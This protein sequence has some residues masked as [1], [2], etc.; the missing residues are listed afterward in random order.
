MVVYPNQRR[1]FLLMLGALGFVVAC[2]LIASGVIE[3]R[4]PFLTISY[5]GVFF[6]GLCLLYMAWRLVAPKP[7]VIV[8]EQGVYDDASL[9]NAGWIGWDEIQDLKISELGQQRF[10]TIILKDEWEVLAR[11]NLPKRYFMVLNA[12]RFFGS[13][14]NIPQVTVPMPLEELRSEILRFRQEEAERTAMGLHGE[15]GALREMP[16]APEAPQDELEKTPQRCSPGPL[17]EKL[18]R[19]SSGPSGEGCSVDSERYP[20]QGQQLRMLEAERTV[21]TP[22]GQRRM[23]ISRLTKLMCSGGGG[24]TRL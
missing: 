15:L 22:A 14:V 1:L 16:G 4:E 19:V 18:R 17:L 24:Q 13:P 9:I 2:T 8:S 11:Q 6:F 20:L 10:L 12:D 23:A 5:L 3:A 7:S 21:G